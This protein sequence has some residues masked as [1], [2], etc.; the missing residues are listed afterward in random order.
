[1]NKIFF[2]FLVL[3]LGACKSNINM[4]EQEKKLRDEIEQHPDSLLLKE[5]LIQYFREN[6]NYG[7][8]IGEAG[9]A[10]KKDSSNERLWYIKATLH[11]ENDD[12]LQAI[13]AFEN[14][15]RIKSRPE[16]IMSL[17]TLYAFSKNPLAIAMADLL[18]AGGAAGQYNSLF[19]K[20]LYHSSTGD[21]TTAAAFFDN[22]IS[23]DYTNTLAY[24]EKAVCQYDAGKYLDAL[25]TLELAVTVKKTYDEAY[26]WMGRCY[27]K[28]ERKK[29]AMENYQLA[30]QIDPNYIEAKDALAKMG[31]VQ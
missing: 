1:M 20:G 4:P 2:F 21:K 23:L 28:L 3:L 17:G 24:R 12:T 15:V 19:I 29:E 18:M 6:S 5:N 7:Q 30:L 22:C 31:V 16:Y 13:N 14:A 27:E 26:Y 10:L 8:A 25:K 9:N 11:A